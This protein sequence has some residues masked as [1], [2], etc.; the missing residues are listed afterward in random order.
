MKF[1]RKASSS[2]DLP[3]LTASGYCLR[4]AANKPSPSRWNITIGCSA[5]PF[6]PQLGDLAVRKSLSAM[7]FRHVRWMK[8][9][10]KVTLAIGVSM[11][12]R[13]SSSVRCMAFR[14]ALMP[15]P[16]SGQSDR[17][18]NTGTEHQCS[19]A[20]VCGPCHGGLPCP[21]GR[22]FGVVSWLNLYIRPILY[23]F[24]PDI[25]KGS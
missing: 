7:T 20:S 10:I 13:P 23:K 14:G 18:V 22:R 21:A 11:R 3:P 1:S 5:D 15:A 24:S 19:T 12:T 4:A 17:K 6:I 25:V 8:S 9:F 2:N 16:I